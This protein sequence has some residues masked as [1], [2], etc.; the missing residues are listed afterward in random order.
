MKWMVMIECHGY[1]PSCL[2][3]EGF[4]REVMVKNCWVFWDKFYP[5]V[6]GNPDDY[7]MNRICSHPINQ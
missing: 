3:V 2:K 6:Q 4:E 7:L 1:N 5:L